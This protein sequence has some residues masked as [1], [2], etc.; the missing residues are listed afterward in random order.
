VSRAPRALERAAA[1]A[2]VDAE[3]EGRHRGARLEAAAG[4][5]PPDAEALDPRGGRLAIEV[6]ELHRVDPVEARARAEGIVAWSAGEL[7]AAV[8]AALA[9]KEERLAR[10]PRALARRYARRVLRLV[11]DERQRLEAAPRAAELAGSAFDEVALLAEEEGGRL[12]VLARS[13]HGA[14]TIRR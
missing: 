12:R 11:L 1:A 14:R 6:T 5:D 2:W 9:R 10:W 13:P 7:R 8:A 3:N 4:P